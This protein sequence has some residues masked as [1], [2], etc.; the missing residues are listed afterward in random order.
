ME[1]IIEYQT[2]SA[3]ECA[4]LD[5]LVN[6]AIQAGFQPYGPPYGSEGGVSQAVVKMATPG[7]DA[8]PLNST[9]AESSGTGRV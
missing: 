1:K 4:D 9:L 2:V 3:F 5:K 7:A 8:K 6:E